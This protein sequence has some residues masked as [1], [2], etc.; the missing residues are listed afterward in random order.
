MIL[1]ILT[2]FLHFNINKLF[3]KFM[4]KWLKTA[5]KYTKIFK[6]YFKKISRNI[7]MIDIPVKTILRFI[8]V[9]LFGQVFRVQLY[10]KVS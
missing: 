1:S 8:S 10:E 3:F 6:L 4:H 2:V 7:N 9:A 5:L